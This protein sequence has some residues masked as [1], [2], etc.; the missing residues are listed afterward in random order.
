MICKSS[1]QNI[2]DD[3]VFVFFSGFGSGHEFW[4]N[5][6]PYFSDFNYVLLSENYFSSPDEVSVEYL[7]EIFQGKRIIGVGH[8]LGYHKLCYL[9]Q[10]YDFFKLCKIVSLEGF[11][12]YLGN[13]PFTAEF[14]KFFLNLMKLSY[15]TFPEVTLYN[16]LLM[17][18]APMQSFPKNM[19]QKLIMNNLELLYSGIESP[20]IPHL[21]LSSYDDWVIPTYIIEDS[22]RNLS[23]VE[24]VYTYGASHLLGIKFPQYVS[25]KILK[26]V[27]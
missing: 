10:K 4:D 14:R 19:N 11:S 13:S 26:F 27:N 6:L 2:N 7:K 18:G 5:L 24:I 12:R 16:F 15:Q 20:E 9:N 23:D 17:C 8:S 1:I 21:V 22:F 3:R 25:Q